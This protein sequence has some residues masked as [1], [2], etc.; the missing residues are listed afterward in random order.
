MEPRPTVA[1]SWMETTL[2]VLQ[3]HPRRQLRLPG[4][5]DNIHIPFQGNDH[6]YEVTSGFCMSRHNIEAWDDV[7]EASTP[8]DPDEAVSA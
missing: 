5:F 1:S 6:T 4:R 3:N 7:A 2:P 8:W